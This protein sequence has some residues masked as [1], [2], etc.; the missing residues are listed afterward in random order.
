MSEHLQLTTP[1]CAER[2]PRCWLRH[3]HCLCGDLQPTATRSSVLVIMHSRET[4]RPSNS[5][6][7]IPLVLSR[8][9]LRLHGA[10]HMATETFD[11]LPAS[12]TQDLLLFPDPS[13]VVLSRALIAEDPRPPRL[14]VPDGSWRQARSMARRRLQRRG[15]RC[16]RVTA[17]EAP[18]PRL[19]RRP[20]EVGLSTLEAVALA[21]GILED[22]A[23]GE[24]LLALFD[25]FVAA[26]FASAGR[27]R[28]D[29]AP[30]DPQ[31]L[32]EG[33]RPS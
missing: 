5:A 15:L 1:R 33:P 8:A 31:R 13:A 4:C 22:P 6:H 28:G 11:D 7:L 12:E 9:E 10:S 20:G 19:R 32:S 27:G 2:C 21:L 17:P 29:H 23:L 24:S 3:A 16:V 25:R 18:R 30:L 14:I 26:S